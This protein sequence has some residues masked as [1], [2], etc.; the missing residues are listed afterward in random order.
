MRAAI[1]HHDSAYGTKRGAALDKGLR[2]RLGARAARVRGPS[3]AGD[4]APQVLEARRSGATALL[5]WARP[6]AVAA[7]VRAARSTGWPVPIYTTTSGEDPLVRQQLS[8]HPEWLDGLTFTSSRLTA[9][10]GP[11]PYERFRS[12]YEK[13]LAP[14]QMR[15]TSNGKPVV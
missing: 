6:A 5:V 13:R 7:V 11:A 1:V 2:R 10:K 14:D 8:D 15:V 12:A 4:P 3:S 9:E